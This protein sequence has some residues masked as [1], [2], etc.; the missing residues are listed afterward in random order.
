MLSSD[1]LQ[2]LYD[3]SRN[4]NRDW[5]EQNKPRYEKAVKKPFEQT[6]A[7][8]I[9]RIQVFEP[10][11]RITPKDCVFRMHRDTRF[12]NDKTP[13]KTH[14]A[15]VFTPRGRQTL[16][17]PGYYLHVEYGALEIG[18]GAYFLE[19]EP[20]HKMRTAIAQDPD[21]FRSLIEA[22]EFQ[23]KYGGLQGEKNKILPPEF[24]AAAAKEPL[25]YNKQYYFMAELDP[26]LA[27]GPG[28]LDLA[29]AYFHSARRLNDFFRK[30]LVPRPVNSV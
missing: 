16:H 20:L 6:V 26:E 15:A 8:V 23:E 25:L 29:A 14:I 4:N 27:L 5:F 21:T 3:L 2:F 9:E 24:K 22:P 13:Y 1:T 30:A 7:A 28:F 12:S 18:G 17:H 10:D 19:K 11:F